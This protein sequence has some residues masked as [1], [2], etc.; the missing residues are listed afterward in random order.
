MH[1]SFQLIYQKLVYRNSLKP[2]Q[3]LGT[4][5]LKIRYIQLILLFFMLVICISLRL[6]ISVA[7]IAM[8]SNSTSSNPDVPVS[9]VF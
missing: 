3:L 2:S 4:Q 8:T 7:I 9:I 5:C 1:S 6:G